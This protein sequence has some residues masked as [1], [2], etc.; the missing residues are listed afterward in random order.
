MRTI[1]LAKMI[2]MKFLISLALMSF[3]FT[4]SSQASLKQSLKQN[5]EKATEK[6]SEFGRTTGRKANDASLTTQVK[7]RLLSDNRIQAANINVDTKNKVVYLKGTVPNQEQRKIAR[8][9][10][11]ST[12]GVVK[13]MDL[14][15]VQS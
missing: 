6:T 1:N 11:R 8:T 2:L 13:V 4:L 14:L 7:T 12:K 9:I 3:L 10:A 5:L 15:K